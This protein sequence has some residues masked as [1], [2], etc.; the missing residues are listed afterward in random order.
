MVWAMTNLL[1]REGLQTQIFHSQA[2]PEEIDDGMLVCGLGSRY[3]DSWLMSRELC[4]ESFAHGASGSDLSLVLGQYA[5]ARSSGR[6]TG[7][8]LE[9]LCDWLALPQVAIVDVSLLGDCC[10]PT[11]PSGVEA[12]LLDRVKPAD[13]FYWRTTLESLWG[14]KVLGALPEL[15]T[16]RDAIVNHPSETLP[17][18]AGFD[19]L[20]DRLADTL[21]LESLLR[22]AVASDS[23]H[24][25]P[26]PDHRHI[27]RPGN[28]FAG[29]TVAVAYDAAFHCYFPG[30]LDLLE[31]QGATVEDFS[32]LHDEALPAH[33]DVVYI[34]CGQPQLF[35]AELSGNHCLAMALRDHARQGR[36]I[37]AEGGGM[38]YLSRS[39]RLSC[40]ESQSGETVPMLGVLPAA[41]TYVADAAPAEAVEILLSRDHWLG[42][43]GA[44]LRGYRNMH[45]QIEPGGPLA[46]YVAN[47]GCELDL[48]GHRQVIGSRLHLDFSAQPDFLR[49]FASSATPSV[50]IGS[51]G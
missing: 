39:L 4:S 22:L 19:E 8:T 51:A 31:L 16:L 18:L 33:T 25:R 28:R 30:V 21:Q 20:G 27:F 32:P 43:A 23:P 11:R 2:K 29:L 12:L 47:P 45:W 9:G 46:S 40:G 7:G 14:V 15:P 34:G 41:A 48:V 42:P 24:A 35:A 26:W 49:R 38:A 50:G 5:S 6:P 13:F 1:Q 37:Y 10:L 3:L 44:Q 36:R 17:C